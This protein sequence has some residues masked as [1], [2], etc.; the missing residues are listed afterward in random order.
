MIGA[1]GSLGVFWSNRLVGTITT[2]AIVLLFW[3][4]IEKVFAGLGR[5]RPARAS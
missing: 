3:P 4:M 1:E 2:L 5:L